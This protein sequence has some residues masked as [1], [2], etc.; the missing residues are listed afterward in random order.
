MK[1]IIRSAKI[2]DSKSPFHNQT[3]DLLIADG[4]IEKIGA[5]LP[6]STEAKEVKFDN[7]HLS[8]GWFDS[9]VSFGEPGY[10]DRETIANGLTVA[11]KSGF[12]GVALQPNSF[13]IIDNQSQ[14]NF[15]KSKANGF[16]TELFPIGALT[17]A[18][19][20]KD[21]AELFDMKKS[22]AVAFGDY[23]KSLDNANLLKIALQYV[24]D[25]DGL[26]VSYSQDVNLKGTGV[27]NE[28]I[29][30]TKLGLKGIPNLAEELQISRNL[31]LLEYTSGKLHIPTVSTAK[32]GALIKEAKA[33][34]LNVTCSAS[35]HHLVLNDEKLEGFD[36]RYKVTPPLRTESDRAAL[37]NAVLDGTI[38]M[39]TSDHNPIDIEFKKMEFDTAKNGTIG[40]ESAFGALLTVLP[41]ET[42]IEKL[43]LGK[44]VFGIENN[45]I[46]EGSKAN[47][48]FFSPEGNS[49]FTKENI[50]SKSK[51][52]AF[53]GT[54]TKGTVY[55][56][57]NQNQL[58]ITK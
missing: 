23:N 6:E 14:I 32:S 49:T 4:I 44:A 48:T 30:S 26:V 57:L 17:K 21:M 13:P 7:L 12:T 22:G 10:E 19:E 36:T 42:V 25:F 45:S 24:Q 34:G 53:L 47:F 52:S 3:V 28:G 11:A 29:I 18:S 43:T 39:I 5:S 15:V 41:L 8:Q 50:L 51:N 56:I 54:E 37:V 40:L 1:I 9:S 35:V 27:V 16:A 33:K 38:D 58:V 31:F 55:G 20:G 2:I 46:A